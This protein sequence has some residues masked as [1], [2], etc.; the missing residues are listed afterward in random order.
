MDFYVG[1]KCA[2]EIT[3]SKI[4]ILNIKNM[5]RT[6]QSLGFNYLKINRFFPQIEY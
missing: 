4:S 3:L 2:K 1:T 6:Q 5:V